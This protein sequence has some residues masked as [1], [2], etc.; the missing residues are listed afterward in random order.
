MKGVYVYIYIYISVIK[1]E[2][3][4]LFFNRDAYI[5]IMPSDGCYTPTFTTVYNLYKANHLIHLQE[6]QIILC[7]DDDFLSFLLKPAI[8]IFLQ[9]SGTSLWSSKLKSPTIFFFL[10]KLSYELF[11][12]MIMVVIWLRVLSIEFPNS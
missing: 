9:I 3:L 11:L 10:S 7:F 5:L 8:L 12:V 1:Q 2:N 6:M 4:I